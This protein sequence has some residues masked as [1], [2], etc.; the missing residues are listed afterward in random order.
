[1][2]RQL[3]RTGLAAAAAIALGLGTS[4]EAQAQTSSGCSTTWTTACASVTVHS[5]AGNQLVV[6]AVNISEDPEGDALHDWLQ[7][8]VDPEASLT[9]TTAW[10]NCGGSDFDPTNAST[11]NDD[12][13][14]SIS[15]YWKAKSNSQGSITWEGAKTTQG[16]SGLVTST[17]LCK[18]EDAC[19]AEDV[20]FV[21]DFGDQNVNFESWSVHATRLGEDN[22][23]SDWIGEVPEPMTTTLVGIGLAAGAAVRRR[24]KNGELDEDEEEPGLA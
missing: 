14:D 8:A 5:G 20:Y 1:M 18:D 12:N 9:G 6:S 19:W 4:A 17:E 13:C 21:M 16:N 24:R 7:V 22:E 15:D 10:V 11:F 2:M 3:W 23:Y